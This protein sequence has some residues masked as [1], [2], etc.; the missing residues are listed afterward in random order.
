MVMEAAEHRN[1]HDATGA[2]SEAMDGRVFL[3]G[4]VG[5]HIVVIGR[6]GVENSAQV[7]YRVEDVEAYEAERAGTITG[8]GK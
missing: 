5:S 4:Q 7:R 3:Q 2:M 6:V 8:S 1:S